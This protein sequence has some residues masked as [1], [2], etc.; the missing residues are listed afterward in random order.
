MK[1]WI[2]SFSFA[3]CAIALA[4][5]AAHAKEVKVKLEDC[6]KAVQQTIKTEVGAGKINE[7]EKEKKANGYVYEAEVVIAGK[8]YDLKVAENGKLLA[9]QLDDDDDDDEDDDDDDDD[10]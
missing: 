8:Q 5:Y 7:I 2:L 3:L 4:A 9:K 6:P 10:D 1:R